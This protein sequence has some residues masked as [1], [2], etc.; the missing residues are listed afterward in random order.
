[1]SHPDLEGIDWRE[2]RKTATVD[3]VQ[4]TEEII[5]DIAAHPDLGYF[6]TGPTNDY[7]LGLSVDTEE[8]RMRAFPGDYLCRGIDDEM[9]PVSE[10]IFERTYVEV[11]QS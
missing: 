5:K 7:E 2:Y 1:M 9:W 3:A 10:D 4:L 6:R 8:G 11:E